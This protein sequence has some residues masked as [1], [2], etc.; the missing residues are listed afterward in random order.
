MYLI[1]R[2]TYILQKHVHVN[3]SSNMLHDKVL[4]CAFFFAD[5]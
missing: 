1:W 2:F 5:F 4:G 3:V